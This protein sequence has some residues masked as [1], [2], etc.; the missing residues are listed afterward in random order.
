M[1]LVSANRAFD[2]HRRGRLSVWR[3]AFGRGGVVLVLGTHTL[4]WVPVLA[5]GVGFEAPPGGQWGFPFLSF[6]WPAP[7]RGRS[8]AACPPPYPFTS[9]PPAT[10]IHMTA[11]RDEIIH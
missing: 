8:A 4:H 9:P 6:G 5:W 2:E 3:F 7:S 10:R 1:P 11:G